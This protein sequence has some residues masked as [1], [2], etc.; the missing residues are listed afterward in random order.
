MRLAR[1]QRLPVVTQA[2]PARRALGA[3]V[4]EQQATLLVPTDHIRLATGRLHG[5][6]RGKRVGSVLQPGL[7]IGPGN[8]RMALRVAFKTGLQGA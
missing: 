8:G 5:K 3:T 1:I 2:A 6:Q 4:A 7:D